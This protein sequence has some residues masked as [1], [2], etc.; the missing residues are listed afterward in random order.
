M[1]LGG[2]ALALNEPRG[3]GNPGLSAPRKRYRAVR[4]DDLSLVI[5]VFSVGRTEAVC[6]S[7]CIENYTQADLSL[8]RVASLWV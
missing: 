2:L 8:G 7:V 5:H 4:K 6:L 3:A 1:S